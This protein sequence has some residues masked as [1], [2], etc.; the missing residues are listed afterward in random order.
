MT[1]FRCPISNALRA[2]SGTEA[3]SASMTT[4]RHSMVELQERRGS[5]RSRVPFRVRTQALW[6]ALHAKGREVPRMGQGHRYALAI[7][8]TLAATLGLASPALASEAGPQWAVSS[9]AR[10]TDFAVGSTEDSYVLL[11]TNGGARPADF[12][13]HAQYEAE[14]DRGESPLCPEDSPPVSSA[15]VDHHGRIAGW[16]GSAAGYLRR[17]HVARQGW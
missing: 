9:V 6:R 2:S 15:P 11:V 1:T 8:A 5:S 10:P 16:C 14:H 17:R 13:T 4:E 3:G 7:V 12:C